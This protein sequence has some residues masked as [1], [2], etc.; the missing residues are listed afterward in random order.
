MLE[1]YFSPFRQNVIGIDAFF[2]S[3]YGKQK[4]IYADWTASGRAY[5]PIEDRLVN[6]IM[7]L[8]GNTHTETTVTGRAM[9]K[10]Y[11]SAKKII[12]QHVNANADDL[13][14]FAGSGMTGAIN[15]LQR[16]L[17][18]RIPERIMDYVRAGSL[19]SPEELATA[20]LKIHSLF[21]DYLEV[22]PQLKPVIFVS[23]MEHHSNQ[24][25]WLETIADVVII[26]NDETGNISLAALEGLLQ[27]YR[28]RIN[29]IAAITG[30]SNVTG[31][32]TPY[33]KVAALVHQYNG[34]CFVDFACSALCCHR[35]ASRR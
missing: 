26:P 33:H 22:D 32:Q 11:E 21:S 13:L 3:P 28:E 15:K 1:K 4:I 2:N 7:P 34:L 16:L 19:P 12:K 30:C 35:H 17:G 23:Q 24:T 8:L 25:S 31:I 9:T 18:L 14:L 29:K 10:A 27:Q 5:K 6:D 20:G